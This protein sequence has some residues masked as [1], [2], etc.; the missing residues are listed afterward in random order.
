MAEVC[1]PIVPPL[2]GTVAVVAGASRGAGRGIALA[3][4]DAGATVHAVGRTRRGSPRTDGLPGTV[5]DTAEE[6]T[7]RGGVG[8]AIHADLTIEEDAREAFERVEA[9]QGRLDVLANAVWGGADAFGSTE[10]WMAAWGRPFWERPSQWPHMM[11]AGP[12]AYFQ[13]SAHAAALMSKTGGGL[14]V[15]VT[16]FVMDDDA[17]AGGA[18]AYSGD[19]LSD[20]A[21]H[22]INR[23]MFGMGHDGRP[24]G[25]AVIALMPGFM[26]TEAVEAFMTSEERRKRF[27]YDRSE[28]PEYLGR[29]VA[30][31][32]AD[33]HVM[34]KVGR[35]RFVADLAA[36]YGFT[37]V[38][39]KVHAR[40]DPHG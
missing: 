10:E 5:D 16:D 22:T 33:P 27:G 19:L 38:D 23:L 28:S 15:G 14:I 6:V 24:H 18:T 25:I 13:A 34:E 26:R 8:I 35:V 2:V 11:D 30:A 37:D 40:F 39:G 21:H 31:L 20:V 3:L 17:A 9:E 29:A 7:R 12:R 4:G 32:A 36:E 1:D